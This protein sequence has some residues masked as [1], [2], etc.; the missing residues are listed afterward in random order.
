MFNPLTSSVAILLGS[1]FYGTTYA[2]ET[3][4]DRLEGGYK[5]NSLISVST[6]DD[7]ALE[8]QGYTELQIEKDSSNSDRARI[9]LRS[10]PSQN[11]ICLLSGN[12]TIQNN[13]L[14]FRESLPANDSKQNCV[15]TVVERGDLITFADENGACKT[16]HCNALADFRNIFISKN[17][18]VLNEK[19]LT[20]LLPNDSDSLCFGRD[21]G[22]SE[23]GKSPKQQLRT[24]RIRLHRQNDTASI[25][26]EAKEFVERVQDSSTYTNHGVCSLLKA[27][28]GR[29]SLGENAG[30][31]A[32]QN[33]KDGSI[34]FMLES[35]T[36]LVKNDDPPKRDSIHITLSS[37]DRSNN[38][39]KLYPEPCPESHSLTPK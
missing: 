39:F 6:I 22:D 7:V 8:N 32:L 24:L 31:I 3:A 29:C 2:N 28:S 27:S 26:L 4:I 15:L 30:D 12:A 5:S 33:N 21:Y 19:S 14:V 10:S 18:R 23:L 35:N 25:S 16:Q 1:L 36:L 20:T 17:S 13:H 9:S 34:F 37:K 38:L 11:Q